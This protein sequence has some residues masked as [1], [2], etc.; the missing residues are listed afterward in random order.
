MRALITLVLLASACPAEAAPHLDVDLGDALPS[1][2]ALP[3]ST[4]VD[5]LPSKRFAAGFVVEGR[6]TQ[7]RPLLEVCGPEVTLSI[8]FGGPSPKRAVRR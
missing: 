4:S 7:A 1:G 6:G 5:L 3:Y 8:R 2:E